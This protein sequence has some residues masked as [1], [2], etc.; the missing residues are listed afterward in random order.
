MACR[1]TWLALGSGPRSLRIRTMS[2]SRSSV[3]ESRRTL[4]SLPLAMSRSVVQRHTP[5]Q[6][7]HAATLCSATAR[8]VR[9]EPPSAVRDRPELGKLT[10]VNVVG[11]RLDHQLGTVEFGV[12]AVVIK[13]SCRGQHH[14]ESRATSAL[15]EQ[16]CSLGRTDYAETAASATIFQPV[17]RRPR[18]RSCRQRRSSPITSGPLRRSSPSMPLFCRGRCTTGCRN[19]YPHPQRII[20]AP[21]STAPSG[22]GAV[23]T[24]QC[25]ASPIRC[26]TRRRSSRHQFRGGL[27]VLYP[28]SWLV[29]ALH[30]LLAARSL[31]LTTL[32]LASP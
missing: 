21:V 2:A 7:A 14:L 23:R 18:R 13:R 32:H 1:T 15:S 28:A 10:L 5:V 9:V 31:P 3:R 19:R 16:I 6:T 11:G 29:G 30:S 8:D 17:T 22:L 26:L 4:R 20:H 12:A 24:S 27:F 25:P